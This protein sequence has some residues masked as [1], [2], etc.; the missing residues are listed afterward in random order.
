MRRHQGLNAFFNHSQ[1]VG[2][3]EESAAVPDGTVPRNHHGIRI[4]DPQEA[5]KGVDLPRSE[6][7]DDSSMSG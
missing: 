4:N 6:P 2:K 5:F 3:S 1:Q 7:R